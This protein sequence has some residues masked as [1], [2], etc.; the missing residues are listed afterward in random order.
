MFVHDLVAFT[1]IDYLLL[2]RTV[3]IGDDADACVVIVGCGDD[4]NYG[5]HPLDGDLSGAANANVAGRVDVG[6]VFGVVFIFDSAGT[7]CAAIAGS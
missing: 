4:A 6:A 1:W 7:D 3:D 5:A 2:H